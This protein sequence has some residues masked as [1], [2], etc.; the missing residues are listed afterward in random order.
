MKLAILPVSNKTM[1]Q[2]I[3][4]KQVILSVSDMHCPSCPKLITLGLKDQKGVTSVAASLENKQVVVDFDPSKIKI[5]DLVSNVKESGY[6]AVPQEDGVVVAPTSNTQVALLSLTGMHCSSCAGLIE[7]SLKKVPGVSEA[8]VNFASEKARIVYNPSTAKIEDLIK[9]VESAGYKANLPGEKEENQKEKRSHE[10]SYWF[11][12]FIMGF[13]LS[14]PMILFM[15]YDFTNAIPYKSLIM[16]YAGIISLVLTTPVLFYVGSNF[17]AGF[18]SALKMRTF[19]M[20]SLIAIGTGTAFVYSVYEFVKYLIETGS[21]IGL[22]GFKVPNLYFEVA[23]FLITFVALG[24]FLEAQAKGKTSEAIE[25]LMGLAPKTARVLRN[26]QSIDIP[27]EQV[28]V[29]DIVIVRPGD[30][31][32]VDGEIISGYSAVDESIL[33]GESLPVE[34]QV[35]SKVYTASINKTGSFEFKTTKIGAD[36]AL[37]QIVKLIEDAQGSKAPIQGVADKI[38][39]IFVPVVIGIAILT[40]VTWFFFLGATLTYS[41]LAFVAVIVIACPCALGLATPTSIMVG[42]GKG[43][44]HGV[45]IKGGEP[46]EM[47]EKIQAIVFDKTGTLTKGNPEVTDFI[48]YLPGDQSILSILYSIEQKSEHPLAEAIV[49]YGQ[50]T[51]AVNYPIDD[52]Q[53]IP[54]HGVKATV[55]GQIY[56]VGNRK[57]LEE[58][59]IP[60]TSGYDMERM[61]NEGKTAMIIANKEKVLGL[62]AVADQV[63]ESSASVV[64]KL[65]QMGIEVYMITGDNRRTA[66]AIAKQ[67]GI[68]NVLAEVL[69]QNKAEEVKKLQDSGLVVAM[70]GDG[71]NDAPALTQADLGIAMASGADIAMES[72]NIVIMN[73]DLN[74]VLTAISLSRETVGKIRQNMFFALFYNVLGIPIAARALA[75]AGLVLKPELAGLAMALSSVS[76]V[77]NS[78]TLKFYK[79]GKFNWISRF[80]PYVMVGLFLGIFIEFAQFS[81]QMGGG[82]IQAKSGLAA[83]VQQTPAVRTV[84]NRILV[85]NPSK[86]AFAGNFPKLFVGVDKL[87]ESIKLEEGS[88]D[89]SSLGSVILGAKEAAMMK[90]EGLIRGINSEIPD[91]FGLSKLKVVGILAPTGTILDE[92]H[93]FS[94]ANLAGLTKAGDDLLV[95]E[96]PLEDLKMFYLYDSNNVP[97]ALKSLINPAKTSYSIDGVT[98]LS[99][100]I[101]YDEA[102]MMIEEKLFQKKFDTIKGLFG[103]D[104][105]I[106]GLPKKTL[107]SLD[108]MHFVPKVFRDNY[109]KS[110]APAIVPTP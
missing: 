106:T 85:D 71:I 24:K 82:E 23:A 6:T 75:F 104:I 29:G 86:I 76:V 89:L 20:D 66:E 80:A 94:K 25:K 93:I 50:N 54:G 56:F 108:M 14:I 4:S 5:T 62:I 48:N 43:A 96:T 51:G 35:G 13:V 39:A 83:Y 9:G 100:A 19:S 42:T 105:I 98:Y 59:Q 78:L 110:Q 99:T 21:I 52:F 33:T 38:S 28:V 18:W 60:L 32:P 49:R 1:A 27:V 67:V 46:L 61:E 92:Y 88:A 70:V 31:I 37:S 8:N 109:Q 102:K 103:N 15:A 107:T 72:G 95:T 16:P 64:H 79:P 53:A 11:S 30:R 2:K 55:N 101:G 68:T 65:T 97:E 22:N 58:N 26:G 45:L 57:L 7:R 91:F 47:A 90:E 81:S 40:F 74:G 73:N 41:L 69:P 17:F 63:K 34:K 87:P 77:T 44:E 10:I 84:I 36:T 12:K 3:K